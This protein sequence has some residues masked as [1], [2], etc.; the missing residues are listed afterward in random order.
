[1]STRRGSTVTAMRLPHDCSTIRGW[2]PANCGVATF[3]LRSRACAGAEHS[4]PLPSPGRR[5]FGFMA[6]AASDRGPLRCWSTH[7]RGTLNRRPILWPGMSPLS[8]AARTVF[9]S[10]PVASAVSWTLKRT[11]S[12]IPHLPNGSRPPRPLRGNSNR[13]MVVCKRP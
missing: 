5:L 2:H 10:S 3:A 1:M 8:I 11:F 9:A 12:G 7:Q 6:H 4:E 13:F